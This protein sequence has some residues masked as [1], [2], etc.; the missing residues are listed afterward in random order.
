MNNGKCCGTCVFHCKANDQDD[1]ICENPE[2][3]NYGV[4]TEYADNCDDHQS[5]DND[6]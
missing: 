2:S 5:R 1:W 6:Y 3:E 4:W